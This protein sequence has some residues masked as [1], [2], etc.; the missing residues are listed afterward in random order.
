MIPDPLTD[1]FSSRIVSWFIIDV[2]L[3]K[4]YPPRR[5]K[6]IISILMEKLY[7]SVHELNKTTNFPF[8]HTQRGLCQGFPLSHLIFLLVAKGLSDRLELFELRW[9][10]HGYPMTRS[11][12]ISHFPL[13]D[14][15]LVFCNGSPKEVGKLREIFS[16][17][18]KSIVM[19]INFHKSFFSKL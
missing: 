11:L 1:Y 13:V 2:D 4:I 12:T 16:I 6:R 3:V 9:E 19:I 18:G 14:D 5:N 8:F 10:F 7:N 15:I 17:F